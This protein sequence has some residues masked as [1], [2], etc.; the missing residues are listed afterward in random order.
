MSRGRPEID[1]EKCKGC[2]LCVGACPEEILRMSGNT[3][4]RQGLPF[5]V[6]SDESKCTACLSCAIICPDTA[7]RILK[8]AVAAGE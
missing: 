5:A 6:C 7:I 3:F 4:N 2:A 8:L 1:R